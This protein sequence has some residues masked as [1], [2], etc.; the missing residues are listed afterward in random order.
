MIR[1]Y[2]YLIFL[3]FI[4]LSLTACFGDSKESVASD[5]VNMEKASDIVEKKEPVLNVWGLPHGPEDMNSI[6]IR[7]NQTL[8]VILRNQGLTHQQIHAL[9]VAAR[10]VFDVRRMAAGRPLIFFHDTDGQLDA[11]IYEENPRDFILFDFRGDTPEVSKH[12]KISE[13]EVRY[14]EATINGSLYQTLTRMGIDHSMTNRLA[15]I[16]AWQVDF[17]RIQRGDS[18][19]VV[20]EEEIIGGEPVGI[21][22]VLAAEFTHRNRTYHAIQFEQNGMS[23]YFDLQ[24][25]ALRS[26]FL[27]APLEYTRISSGF[28]NRRF[29]PVLGRNMPH[30][31]TDY[32]APTGTPI[33]AVADGVVTVASTDRNNGNWVKIRHNSVYETGY[34]HMSRFGAG[35]R[36]G[37]EVKQGQI[38]GYVGAT[39]LATGPHLCYRF[40]VNGRPADPRRIELPPSDPIDEAYREIYEEHVFRSLTLMRRM[41]QDFEYQS[42]LVNMQNRPQVSETFSNGTL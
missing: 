24:G 20:Y 7:R 22:R 32:A 15:D 11:I 6:R 13:R 18:F 2:T 34:L 30:H 42:L 12:S 3:I 21:G 23:D 16:F 8:S 25:N 41:E 9:S 14:A 29:H 36:R 39:G 1:Y 35:V 37:V 17:Y 27:R 26:E 38:I 10:P 19:K 31:G 28:S 5:E 4:S 33:R 40:W